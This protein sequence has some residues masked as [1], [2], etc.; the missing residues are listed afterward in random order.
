MAS[1]IATVVV[2]TVLL[3]G[4]G[5]DKG[6]TTVDQSLSESKARDR[7]NTYLAETLKALPPSVGLSLAPD[8]PNL[9]SLGPKAAIVVPCTDGAPTE[10]TPLQSQISYWLVGV[11]AG[12]GQEYFT[13]IHT[14]WTQRGWKLNPHSDARWAT[15]LT[16]D[17]Y[18]LTVQDAGK[19]DGSLSI[20]AGSPCFP[21]SAKGGASPQPTAIPHPA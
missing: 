4:C 12:Q 8:N 6:A 13:R 1:V 9:A 7:I 14:I 17:G 18:S 15:V 3:T 5:S 10:G 21:A 19:G 16:P 20:T 11:P 2:A